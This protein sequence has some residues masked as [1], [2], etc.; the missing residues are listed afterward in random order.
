MLQKMHKLAIIN[1]P[2]LYS[3]CL[4]CVRKASYCLYLLC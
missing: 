2:S 4:L 3:F 1:M